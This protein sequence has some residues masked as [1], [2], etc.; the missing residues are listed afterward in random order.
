MVETT[1]EKLVLRNRIIGL[2]LRDARERAEKTK[3]TEA[4]ETQLK[5]ARDRLRELLTT[6]QEAVL[7]VEGVL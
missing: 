7:L 3:K 1:E 2:L 5:T 6:R 4:L